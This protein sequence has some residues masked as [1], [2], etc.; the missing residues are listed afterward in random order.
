MADNPIPQAV[1]DALNQLTAF[2]AYSTALLAQEDVA[3]HPAGL[4]D[5]LRKVDAAYLIVLNVLST[6]PVA[7]KYAEMEQPA[8]AAVGAPTPPPAPEEEL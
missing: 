3:A 4:P 8:M 5:S 6:H 7:T 2:R 1:Q